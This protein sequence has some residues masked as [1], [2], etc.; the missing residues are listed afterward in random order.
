M[1]EW[2][3]TFQFEEKVRQSFGV[4]KIRSEFVDQLYDNLMQR[5]STKSQKR[6]PLFG[7]RPAWT[8]VLSI[9]LLLIIG[10]LVIGPERVYAAIP[11]WVCARG[12]LCQHG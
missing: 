9:L 11:F 12:W 7:L 10:T 3:S 4:P 5:V 6:R 8:V 2:N 1:N